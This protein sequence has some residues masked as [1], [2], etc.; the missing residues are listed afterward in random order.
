M[1]NYGV[2]EYFCSGSVYSLYGGDL[3]LGANSAEYSHLFTKGIKMYLSESRD[4][5]LQL[6]LIY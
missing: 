6:A 5:T 1:G 4:L 2:Y 3:N